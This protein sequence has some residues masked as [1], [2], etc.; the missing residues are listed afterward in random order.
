[1]DSWEQSSEEQIKQKQKAEEIKQFLKSLGGCVYMLFFIGSIIGLCVHNNKQ[2]KDHLNVV[3]ENKDGKLLVE[4]VNT[5]EKRIV[6]L[7]YGAIHDKDQALIFPGDTINVRQKEDV[8]KQGKII[9]AN[10]AH[11]DVNKDSLYVRKQRALFNVE[12]QQMIRQR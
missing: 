11:V 7:W 4:D 6:E 1:M 9:N 3:I 8:Y 10:N 2:K 5:K 12:K